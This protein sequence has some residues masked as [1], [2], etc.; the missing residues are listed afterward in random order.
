M[1]IAEALM[2]FTAP[3]L[4]GMT[5][6]HVLGRRDILESMV[7]GYWIGLGTIS[8]TLFILNQAFDVKFSYQTGMML[9]TIVATISTIYLAFKRKSFTLEIGSKPKFKFT[10]IVLLAA[11]FILLINMAIREL[12]YPILDPDAQ[13]YTVAIA[14][15][16]YD[17]GELPTTISMT[18]HVEN[19]Y[20]FPM[21]FQLQQV[22][23]TML[24]PN[25]DFFLVRLLY[26][27]MGASTII[28]FYKL[29]NKIFKKRTLTL[30]ATLLILSDDS[31]IMYNYVDM[32]HKPIAALY[33]LIATYYLI[34]YM[35]GQKPKTALLIGLFAGMA[36]FVNQLGVIFAIS[37]II[38]A[39]AIQLKNK[40]K[41]IHTVA[42]ILGALTVSAPFYLRNLVLLKNPFYPHAYGIFGGLN[43]DIVTG[44]WSSE[45][46]LGSIY[47]INPFMNFSEA[48]YNLLGTAVLDGNILLFSLF[49]VGLVCLRN[50]PYGYKVL[51]FITTT[52]ITLLVLASFTGSGVARTHTGHWAYVSHVYPLMAIVGV[53]AETESRRK[54]CMALCSV[55]AVVAIALL[56]N[57]TSPPVYSVA[58]R[59]IFYI[60]LIIQV[61][62]LAFW[63][64]HLLRGVKMDITK[65]TTTIMLVLLL[66]PSFYFVLNSK[67]R[68]FEIKDG[69]PVFSTLFPSPD[70]VFKNSLKDNYYII[71]WIN[72]ESPKNAKI[73]TSYPMHLYLDRDVVPLDT[74]GL[75]R[76]YER[77]S[78]EEEL[79]Q[80]LKQIGITHVL[81]VKNLTYVKTFDSHI[82]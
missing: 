75:V 64:T 66:L 2:S 17:K 19:F 44:R 25:F 70:Y 74:Y 41:P 45:P 22:W 61:S 77:G 30:F 38:I 24:Q 31:W 8:V 68:V 3:L 53:G 67:Y 5:I 82:Q 49:L 18:S 26:M 20:A 9:S 1:L 42:L 27:I 81:Y 76:L 51:A 16:I 48:V 12:I 14:K 33:S 80:A 65:V 39:W 78:S 79:I 32:N 28:V 58:S 62:F 10:T 6:L 40:A 47:N 54:K 13:T 69:Q 23:V 56:V 36:A 37:I 35:E 60:P 71:K 73:L 72:E 29:A 7:F 57:L 63:L 11:I 50:K 15:K 21:M 46:I 43:Y 4:L 59:P 34:E 55:S 52:Y